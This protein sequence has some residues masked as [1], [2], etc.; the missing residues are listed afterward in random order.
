[1]TRSVYTERAWTVYLSHILVQQ[2]ERVAH[3]EVLPMQDEVGPIPFPQPHNQLINE[4]VILPAPHTL[5]CNTSGIAF[6]LLSCS[7][8]L[9]GVHAYASLCRFDT[10]REALSL[11]ACHFI[12]IIMLVCLS[13]ARQT[14]A[15]S[16]H[17]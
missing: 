12:S 11:S 7:M 10:S 8:Q 15:K 16:V 14:F 13:H 4:F 3:I 6:S 9:I 2:A 1:M 5:L 17:S